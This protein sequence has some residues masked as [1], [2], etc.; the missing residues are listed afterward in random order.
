MKAEAKPQEK[1]DDSENEDEIIEGGEDASVAATIT[2]KL[3]Q[4]D[5]LADFHKLEVMMLNRHEFESWEAK[6]L[7]IFA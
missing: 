7:K 1:E 4:A 2:H 5:P 6:K 3:G